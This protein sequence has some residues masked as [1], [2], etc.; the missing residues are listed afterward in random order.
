[1][2]SMTVYIK[3]K[4]TTLTTQFGSSPAGRWTSSAA[5]WY[6][7]SVRSVWEHKVLP[8]N[9]N[10]LIHSLKCG[11]L[12][13]NIN[14]TAITNTHRHSVTKWQQLTRA[15]TYF[16]HHLTKQKKREKRRN[17]E[18]SSY[19]SQAHAGSASLLISINCKLWCDGL[20]QVKSQSHTWNKKLLCYKV[21]CFKYY[22]LVCH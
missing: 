13:H 7:G 18:G 4:W 5:A 3:V 2:R 21:L 19:E 20:I 14:N 10:V 12:H 8:N 1:M 6:S 15:L 11:P 9:T 22:A 17:I 16:C